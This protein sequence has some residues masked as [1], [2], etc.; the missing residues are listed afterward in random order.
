MVVGKMIKPKKIWLDASTVCQLKCHSCPTANGETGKNLGRGFL[1]FTDFKK[2][3]DKNPQ[4]SS[5]EL[6]NWGEI[7][8]NK[9]LHQIIEYA[10]KKNVA[11]SAASGVNLNTVDETVIEAMV[12]YK[13]RQITCAIDGTNQKTY[14]TYRVNGNFDQVIENIKAINRFKKKYNSFSPVLKWQ[15]IIFGHNENEISEARKMARDLN[16]I[17]YLKLNWEDLFAEPFSPVKNAEL[18]RKETG[19]G[20]ANRNEFRQKYKKD[21]CYVCVKMW[22]SPQINYDGRVLGCD[23]NYWGDY[24]NILD[25]GFLESINS[26]KMNYAREMLM[27]KQEER[28]DIPCSTC[29]YYTW[30]KETSTWVTDKDI[31]HFNMRSRKFVMLENKLFGLKS[32]N[33]L[34]QRLL[35]AKQRLKQK[36]S[37]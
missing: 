3:V 21:Y 32:I 11:L 19:L 22:D 29:K 13:F 28:D 8:L 31:E 23:T 36:K 15:F 4:L 6:S 35:E 10:Y 9:E 17:F 12:K 26:E 27:G 25:G 30:K 33:I 14:S 18:I 37:D 20:A 16:M 34:A 5:V 1:R 7:F 2:I 24:G